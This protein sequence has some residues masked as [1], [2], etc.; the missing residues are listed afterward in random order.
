MSGARDSVATLRLRRCEGWP[1]EWA[2][3][4]GALFPYALSVHRECSAQHDDLVVQVAFAPPPKPA[5][6]A[7]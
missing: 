4:G 5:A 6:P 1:E 3:I 2:G 7:A